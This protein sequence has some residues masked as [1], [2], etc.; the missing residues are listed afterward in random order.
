M[1][2][3]VIALAL[4]ASALSANAQEFSFGQALG[5]VTGAV[6]GNHFGGGTGNIA[7]TAIGAVVGSEVGRNLSNQRNYYVP[8]GSYRP[9]IAGY[10]QP[11]DMARGNTVNI[12]ANRAQSEL[13][14]CIGDGVYNGVYNPDAAAAYCR[15]AIEAQRRRQ[16]QAEMDAYSQGLRHNFNQ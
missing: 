13:E 14:Q 6:I 11:Y 3:T 16:A 7:M 10:N 12:R 9:P 2:R 15:G 1:K 4:A 8:Q 5:A